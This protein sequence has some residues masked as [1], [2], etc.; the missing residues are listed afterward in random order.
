MA[1]DIK[2]KAEEIISKIKSDKDLAAKFKAD[3]VQAVEGLLG[4]DLPDD[5]TEKIVDTVKA[6]LTA[7][8]LTDI[9]GKLGGMF[10]K[11]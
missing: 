4:V 11:K 1:M 5:V 9:A 10:G 3:P 7:D 2:A 8:Q 6:K